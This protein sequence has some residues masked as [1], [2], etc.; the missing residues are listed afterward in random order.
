MSAFGWTGPPV[1]VM[2][3]GLLAVRAE[4]RALVVSPE[5]AIDLYAPIDGMPSPRPLLDV[6][7]IV[8]LDKP[9]HPDWVRTIVEQCR[10]A[11]VPVVFLGWGEW[12]PYQSMDE[13]L[14]ADFDVRTARVKWIGE[15][16][17]FHRVGIERSGALLD[18]QPFEDVP[19]W[20][21]V[22]G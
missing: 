16:Q 6:V 17:R 14:V 4:R 19:T 7:F 8:G 20:L 18:G 10:K 3:P 5:E 22:G 12:V 13:S 15:D 11:G 21:G 9:M 1:G 2:R